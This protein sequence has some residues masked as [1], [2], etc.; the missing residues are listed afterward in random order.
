MRQKVARSLP[1][2][3][4]KSDLS[5]PPR[6]A[7]L[8]ISFG[9][10]SVTLLSILDW[11]LSQQLS[12]TSRVG[13]ELEVLHVDDAD[14]TDP[15]APSARGHIEKLRARFP[16]HAYHLRRPEPL[17]TPSPSGHPTNGASDNGSAAATQDLPSLLSALPSASSRADILSISRRKAIAQAAHDLSCDTVLYAHSTTRLAER[18]LSETAKGRGFS[19]PFLTTDGPAAPDEVPTVYPMREL[20]KREI[21]MFAARTGLDELV[22]PEA[23]RARHVA[24]KNASIDELMGEYFESVEASYPSIVANVVRTTGRLQAPPPEEGDAVLCILCGFVLPKNGRASER[25]AGLQERSVTAE[26][27]RDD[28]SAPLCYGCMRS[29]S[30]AR[31]PS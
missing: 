4:V 15:S 7:L 21:S 1:S 19:L 22:P 17:E 6:K 18:V 26:D 10:C 13:Y 3:S 20:L 28:D 9:V 27:G 8:P 31:I 25:W 5:I 29:L 14:V 11:H 12:K 30:G 24:A 23:P 2:F 16:R